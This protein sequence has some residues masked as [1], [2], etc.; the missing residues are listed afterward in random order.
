MPVTDSIEELAGFWDRH[1]LTDFENCLEEAPE[2]VFVHAK[3][4]SVCIQLRPAEAQHLTKI[5][6]SRGV[7]EI[8]V[9]KQWIRERLCESSPLQRRPDKA[10]RAQAGSR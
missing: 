10:L 1:D 9:L 5:A 8:T 2:P 6:R 3:G 4:A 7:R